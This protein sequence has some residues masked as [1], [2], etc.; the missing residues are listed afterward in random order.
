MESFANQPPLLFCLVANFLLLM[1]TVIRELLSIPKQESRYLSGKPVSVK[2]KNYIS[3]FSLLIFID[4]ITRNYK[5]YEYSSFAN[6]G[7]RKR[8]GLR[9]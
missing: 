2:G 6:V 3:S 1:G 7:T 9:C 4:F 5:S 8:N